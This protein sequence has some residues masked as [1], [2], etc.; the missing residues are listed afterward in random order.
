[1]VTWGMRA[2]S[3]RKR[4]DNSEPAS[5][6]A[7]SSALTVCETLSRLDCPARSTLELR[8]MAKAE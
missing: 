8:Q 3:G 5:C 4:G 6:T 1:M 7:P 2:V